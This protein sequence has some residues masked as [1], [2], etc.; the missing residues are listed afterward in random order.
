MR[1]LTTLLVSF[2]TVPFLVISAQDF[3][4]KSPDGNISFNVRNG[5]KLIYSVSFKGKP[6]IDP[7]VIGFEFKGEDQMNGNYSVTGQAVTSID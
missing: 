7:S 1:Q 5:E 4:V 2:F 3:T 6:V